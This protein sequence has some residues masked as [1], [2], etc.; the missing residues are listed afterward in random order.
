MSQIVACVGPRKWL[1]CITI[2]IMIA[3]EAVQNFNLTYDRL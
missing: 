1:T 2:W 3:D